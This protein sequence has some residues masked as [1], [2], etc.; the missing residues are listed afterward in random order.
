M[1]RTE[2]KVRYKNSVL[3]FAWSL[4][5]PLLYLVVFYIAFDLILGAGIPAFPTVPA[6]GPARVEPVLGRA[7]RRDAVPSSATPA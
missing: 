4:V 5:N 7:R 1:V 3:G 6:V 2:L